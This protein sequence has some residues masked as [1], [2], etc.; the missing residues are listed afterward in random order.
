MKH[1]VTLAKWLIAGITLAALI[2]SA[3]SVLPAIGQ[4]FQSNDVP[5]DVPVG[6]LENA[7]EF[8]NLTG[9]L[10]DVPD[11]QTEGGTEGSIEL[12][13]NVQVIGAA[14]FKN[15]GVLPDGFFFSFFS[16]ILRSKGEVVC[17]AAPV[18]P[19]DGSEIY[20]FWATV[21]DNDPN[22]NIFLRLFAVDNYGETVT[23]MAY[24]VSADSPNLQQLSDLTIVQPIVVY[25]AYSYFIGTCLSGTSINLISA[26][27]WW[28]P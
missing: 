14:D 2:F 23:D 6:V 8:S 18:D 26:R 10:V 20:Q 28:N 16:G 9:D 5:P 15:D 1:R 27:V 22:A 11:G 19:P 7:I 12:S 3:N 13:T 25:P 17:M 4:R 24:L 21:S